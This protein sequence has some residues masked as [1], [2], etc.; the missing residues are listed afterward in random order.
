MNESSFYKDLTPL[1][2]PLTSVFQEQHFQNVP[3]G[4]HVI[5]TDVKNSTLAVSLGRHY[6]VNLVAA[7]SL[8]AALN[9]AKRHKIEIPFFFGGDGS[10][11]LVPDPIHEEVM[12]GLRAHN[13]N[14]K[15]N[16]KLEMHIG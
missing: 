7:A 8:M 4:W 6:D 13:R 2:L 9:I 10:T 1:K 11:L 12:E 15:R 3:P 14:V 16:F 5:I